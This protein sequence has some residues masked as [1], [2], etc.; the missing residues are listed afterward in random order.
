[1]DGDIMPIP[2]YCDLLYE[3]KSI[4]RMSNLIQIMHF[5][6]SVPEQSGCLP[7]DYPS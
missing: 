3:E 2:F 7:C 5:I 1:M 6:H 4:T